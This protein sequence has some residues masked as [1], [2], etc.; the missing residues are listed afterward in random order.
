MM[1]SPLYDVVA[2]VGDE[3]AT[4]TVEVERGF[5]VMKDRPC[6]GSRLLLPTRTSPA[7]LHLNIN[8]NTSTSAAHH[9]SLASLE[10][11]NTI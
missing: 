1:Q 10:P 5:G 3:E 9:L 8:I 7:N 2:V 11:V 4:M 6:R